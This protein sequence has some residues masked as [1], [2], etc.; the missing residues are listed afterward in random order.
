MNLIDT[1]D[2]Q[3]QLRFQLPIVGHHIQLVLKFE[4]HT[5][6]MYRLDHMIQTNLVNQLI[7][8]NL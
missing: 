2:F 7:L 6:R 1:Y 8:I 5:L 4:N 3:I